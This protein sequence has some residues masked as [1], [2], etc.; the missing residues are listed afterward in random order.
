MF[1]CFLLS[2]W[3]VGAR[4][5]IGKAYAASIDEESGS[6]PYPLESV[7]PRA[8]LARFHGVRSLR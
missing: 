8:R 2:F 1:A 6:R 5:D 7:S 3:H 4:L